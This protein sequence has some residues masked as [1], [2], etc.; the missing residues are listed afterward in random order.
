M[1][2]PEGFH[3]YDGVLFYERLFPASALDA[4][5]EFKVRKDDLYVLTYPKSGTTWTQEIV[6]LIKDSDDLDSTDKIPIRKRV[7]FLE[8]V[9][10]GEERIPISKVLDTMES[11][12][13][14]KTHLIKRLLPPDI[15]TVKPKVVYV[16]RN[17]KDVLV[18]YY[19]FN[20]HPWPWEEYFT[21]FLKGNVCNGSW[22]E[23][24]EYWWEHR[25]DDNI[26]F[27]FYEELKRDLKGH[28][29][30]IANFLNKPLDEATVDEITRRSSFDAMKD[31]P[32]VNFKTFIG[33]GQ[34]QLRRGQS[35][36]WKTRLTE[37]EN[38]AIEKAFS[39]R[40]EEINFEFPS[41]S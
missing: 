12:R 17:P 39:K 18:S 2:A 6:S 14:I 7:P 34:R 28:V 31:N 25:N 35:G 36:A 23:N 32:S 9:P 40:L 33:D 1:S 24:V 26:L 19:E 16:A 22:L 30:K 41:D 8:I 3:Y 11:P 10:P 13:Y 21:N 37:A 20:L 4:V 27:L 29:R 38:E 5:K 15:F